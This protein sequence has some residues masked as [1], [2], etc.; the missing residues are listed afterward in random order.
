MKWDIYKLQSPSGKIYIGQTVNINK[1]FSEYKTFHHCENQKKLFNALKKYGWENFNKEILE[2]IEEEIIENLK[3]TLNEL[4]IK[5][6]SEYDCVKSGYNICLGGNQHRLGVKETEE[7]I[8]KKRDAWTDEKRKAQSEKFKG[9]LNPRF[10][11]TE[12]TYSKEVNQYDIDGKYI[13][14]WES[15]AVIERE[16]GYNAKNIS[17]VCLGKNLTSC[18]F[19]WKF[20]ENSIDNILPKESKRGKKSIKG[21][22]VIPI[23]Q[24]SITGI[25][26]ER[27]SSITDA[28]EKLNIYHSNISACAKGK[29]K[30]AGG[31]IWKYSM[32]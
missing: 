3:N 22:H 14:T 8:Q 29:R 26:I 5:Y 27:F 23:F 11:S 31:Y 13:K 28:E 12:K 32:E 15:A 20:F 7:Q 17:G 10:G 24:Y 1:R 6:I 9:E 30:T 2:T 18:G 16:L 25:L 21:I 19:I 4:E